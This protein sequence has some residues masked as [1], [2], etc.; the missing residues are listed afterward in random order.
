MTSTRRSSFFSFSAGRW[1]TLWP[2]FWPIDVLHNFPYDF[3]S[4]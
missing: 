4:F 1:R 2:E 3:S